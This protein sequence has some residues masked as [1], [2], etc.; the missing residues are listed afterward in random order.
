MYK[1]TKDNTSVI[2]LSDGAHIPLAPGNRDYS[3]YQE[4]LAA[5]NTPQPVDPPTEEELR[6]AWKMERQ[7][8]VDNIKVTVGDKVFDGDE[9]SQG[10]MSRSIVAMNDTETILWVLADNTP[11]QC[12]KAEL[13]EALRLAGQAQTEV[14][15]YNPVTQ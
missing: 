14:W 1:L 7:R 12:T 15:V 10:R 8:L 13:M 3:E 6:M 9:I 2:R 11:T 5:G 4:W